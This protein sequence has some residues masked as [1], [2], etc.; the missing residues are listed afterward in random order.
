MRTT[1]C[2]L[3][4]LS[5][6]GGRAARAQDEEAVAPLLRSYESPAVEVVQPRAVEKAG[7]MELVGLLGVMPNDAFLVYL[8]VGL[9]LARHFSERWAV[10]LSAEY[11][12]SFDSGLKRF[13]EENDA[14]LRARIRD[15][16]QLRFSASALWS[17]IY[18]KLAAF[19]GLLHLDG[20]LLAGA[21]VVRTTEEEAIR[22][23]AAVRPDFHL[24]MGLRAFLGR[25]WVLRL[26]FRQHFFLHP[27]DESGRGGG[28][29]YPSELALCSGLL[30]GGRR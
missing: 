27:E 29:G 8:P 26:E 14:E 28:L 15:R 16:Q 25:R 7:R 12:F 10:E 17:P 5:L 4:V 13:L 23:D 9:R 1:S 2:V 21:G 24:G 18:G 30:W 22:L 19:G 3:L 11:I 20:Y 6:L